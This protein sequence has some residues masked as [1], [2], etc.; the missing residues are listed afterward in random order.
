MI[1][2]QRR[3]TLLQQILIITAVLKLRQ[4]K[5]RA[6]KPF[7]VMA[8]NIQTIKR[9][10]VV[11]NAVEEMI[12]RPE[13]PIVIFEWFRR[14]FS[15]YVAPD[16]NKIGVMAAYT[17]LHIVLFQFMKTKFI[18]A[19]SANHKHEPVAKN[20]EEAERN[21][22]EFTDVFLHHNREIFQRDKL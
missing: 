5:K 15:D 1:N 2:A 6:T 20:Q 4:L 19:T 9:Y 7:A 13:S 22:S 14:P 11:P 10:A 8:E 3:I 12:T 17:P 18:I 21:L 16:S